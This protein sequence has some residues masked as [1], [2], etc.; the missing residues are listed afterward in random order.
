MLYSLVLDIHEG[1]DGIG[2][3]KP[4]PVNFLVKQIL[5][6]LELFKSGVIQVLYAVSF[7]PDAPCFLDIRQ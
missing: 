3:S 6:I 4:S 7:A 5:S 2:R 1:G